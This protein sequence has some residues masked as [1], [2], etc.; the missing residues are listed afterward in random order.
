MGNLSQPLLDWLEFT[1]ILLA[2]SSRAKILRNSLKTFSSI[3]WSITIHQTTS[4]SLLLCTF[5]A[6]CSFCMLS[7]T[8]RWIAWLSGKELSL[9]THLESSMRKRGGVGSV[10][11]FSRLFFCL[12]LLYSCL[13]FPFVCFT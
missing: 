2:F 9:L 11:L 13:L 10:N 1:T 5:L 12:V 6:L 3:G 4:V 8:S 7:W